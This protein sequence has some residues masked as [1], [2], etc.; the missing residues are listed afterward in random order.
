MS[1]RNGS[2]PNITHSYYSTYNAST[3]YLGPQHKPYF[4]I[5][6]IILTVFNIFP[7][8]L[9]FA[10]PTT[11][12]QKTLG[13]FPRVNWHFL[14]TFKDHFQGCYKNGTN[15]TWDYRYIA[16]MYLL[17]RIIYHILDIII[18]KY[19]YNNVLYFLTPLSMS[20]IFG[21]LRPYRT[22][23]YNRLDS[24]YFGLLTFAQMW[25]ICP[26]F[27]TTVPFIV[28]YISICVP[29]FHTIFVLLIYIALPI[30]KFCY[31]R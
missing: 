27:I 30:I 23:A 9:M 1:Q 19:N 4:I 5:A 6:V 7:M 20:L 21:I 26:V 18:L 17:I 31:I 29:L 15:N 10:Y 14:H 11:L 22:D 25:V 24:V 8:L 16:G 2:H 28:I 3:P 13:C 12:F